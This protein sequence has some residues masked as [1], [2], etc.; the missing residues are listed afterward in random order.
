ML[1]RRAAFLHPIPTI[2]SCIHHSALH[3]VALHL[4]VTSVAAIRTPAIAA[5]VD[6][7]NVDMTCAY[8]KNVFISVSTG[9][10]FLQHLHTSI[11]PPTPMCS[12]LH[13]CHIMSRFLYTRPSHCNTAF[14]HACAALT[15][16][17]AIA[18]SPTHIWCP[19]SHARSLFSRS[20]VFVVLWYFLCLGPPLWASGRPGLLDTLSTHQLFARYA[21]ALSGRST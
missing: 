14:P 13:A 20:A 6:M 15:H 17:L 21:H 16:L 4:G 11:F 2:S 19:R 10:A 3:A 12:R 9:V 18:V 5:Y 8:S 1:L 7:V